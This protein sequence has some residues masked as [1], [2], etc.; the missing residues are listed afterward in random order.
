[1][2]VFLLLSA[3]A[4]RG[5]EPVPTTIEGATSVHWISPENTPQDTHVHPLM[6]PFFPG[7]RQVDCYSIAKAQRDGPA[8]HD[9]FCV[10]HYGNAANRAR[11]RALAAAP[12]VLAR[13]VGEQ[14]IF[15]FPI[16]E[17]GE[18]ERRYR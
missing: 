18:A 5:L 12:D 11:V 1:M 13:D 8:L 10:A 14:T 2:T 4:C 17:L 15:T 6:G 9:V 16:R 3:L 7:Y